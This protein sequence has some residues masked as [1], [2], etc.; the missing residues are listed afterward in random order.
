MRRTAPR[1]PQK[2]ILVFLKAGDTPL[3]ALKGQREEGNLSLDHNVWGW[4]SGERGPGAFNT[5]TV[6]VW[7]VRGQRGE[8]VFL[9]KG[10]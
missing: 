6:C 2:E 10:W 5:L 1:L 7:G 4:G 3:R 8:L 9:K